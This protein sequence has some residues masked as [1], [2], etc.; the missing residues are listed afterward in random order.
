MSLPKTGLSWIY[1]ECDASLTWTYYRGRVNGFSGCI[2]FSVSFTGAIGY[3]N[4]IIF[5]YNSTHNNGVMQNE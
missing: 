5:C 3:L 4:S 2:N 1:E